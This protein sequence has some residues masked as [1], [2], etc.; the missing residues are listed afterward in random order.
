PREQ[1]LAAERLDDIVVG[2]GAE[3]PYLVDLAA[4]RGEQDHRHVAEVA[5]PL[6]RLETVELRHR[7]VEDDEVG[8]AVVEGAERGAPVPRGRDVVAS[9]WKKLL[10]QR[11]EVVIVVDD[12]HP[13]QRCRH[14]RTQYEDRS[15]R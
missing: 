15:G 6:E 7:E 5:E 2:A 1:L 12:E 13:P 10:E 14:H 9:A 4:P 11:A 3:A 8:P